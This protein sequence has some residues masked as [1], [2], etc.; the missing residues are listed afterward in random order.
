M[1]CACDEHCD[2]TSGL[3][4][5]LLDCESQ[6]THGRVSALSVSLSLASALYT[7]ALNSLAVNTSLLVYGTLL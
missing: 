3:Y 2:H 6:L 7:A 1:Y 4:T 5:A